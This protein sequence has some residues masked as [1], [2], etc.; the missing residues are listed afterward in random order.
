MTTTGPTTPTDAGAE[1]FRIEKDALGEVRVPADHYW[2]AQTQ[3]SVENFRI[4]VGRFTWGRPVIRALGILKLCAAR[5]NLELG[6]LAP[7]RVALIEAAAREVIDGRLDDEFPL[8]V[9]QTGSGT[10]T[11]MNANE[12]I[13]G[14][15]NELAGAR[16]GGKSPIHPNDDVNRS[17]SSNDA[18]PTV[19]HIATV[20]EIEGAVIPAIEA[21]RDT[22]RAKSA[23]FHEV[24]MLG[25]THLQDAT[26]VTLG[27]VIGGWA[28]QLDGALGGIRSTLPA[29]YGLAL[30]GTAVGT[31]LHADPRFGDL[32]ARRIADETGRPFR[33]APDKFAALSA[34]DPLV[35]VSA[36]LRTLA[37]AAMKIANDV[38][39][40]ASGPRAGIGEL[41][42]PEN[43]PGS[44]IMPGK[45]NPTQSEALTQV[46]VQVFG[47]DAAV[48][49]AGSQGNFQLNVYKPVMLDNVLTAATLLAEALRSFNDHCAVGIEPN[50]P[51]IREHLE[52]SLMLVTALNPHIGYEKSAEIALHAHRTGTSLRAAAHELGHLTDEQFDAW[53]VPAAMTH[54]LSET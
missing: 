4:G 10:Q 42:I 53:V 25:R 13:A 1:G 23:V 27:Q 47:C 40:Y 41:L 17:Q 2:G 50:L 21:L 36:A 32:A 8:V 18:F 37:V 26:P 16:R 5:A 11:N 12:V 51:R 9:F 6:Q 39:W 33:G 45:I 52:D 35:A 28:A 24:V 15:A 54:P 38:R 19:M 43:E 3:R 14:R 48:A 20:E 46:V 29:L 44:S 49:F 31:G 30:G 22:L 7:D 34:H